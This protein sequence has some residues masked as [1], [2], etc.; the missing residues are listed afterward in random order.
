MRYLVMSIYCRV[1]NDF[2]E[3]LLEL[4]LVIISYHGGIE[5]DSMAFDY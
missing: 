5:L 2:S 3:L 1:L 4:Q